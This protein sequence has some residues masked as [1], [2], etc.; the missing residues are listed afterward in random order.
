M[1]EP[2]ELGSLS[3]K[4]TRRKSLSWF[5]EVHLIDL[6]WLAINHVYHCLIQVLLNQ[7][8]R[9]VIQKARLLPLKWLLDPHL[10][11][12]PWEDV[13]F[14]QGVQRRKGNFTARQA[15]VAS[16][17]SNNLLQALSQERIATKKGSN[18]MPSLFHMAKSPQHK[19]SF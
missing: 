11:Q 1:F 5:L 9:P 19:S 3:I 18:S 6:L 15:T 2:S 4:G 16:A 10:E 14:G 17:T 13:L 7:G 8:H 12:K